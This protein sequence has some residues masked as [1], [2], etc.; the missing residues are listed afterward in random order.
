M[1]GM[2]FAEFAVLLKL[3]SV[4]IVFLVLLGLVVSLLALAARQ[5]NFYSH[6][7]T[8]WIIGQFLPPSKRNVHKFLHK[9]INPF[10]GI[11]IIARPSQYVKRFFQYLLNFSAGLIIIN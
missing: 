2:L 4:G 3:D 6:I 10:R 8:S 5:G 11:S 7:G 1:H 9:K